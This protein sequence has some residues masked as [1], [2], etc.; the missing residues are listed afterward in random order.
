[1]SEHDLNNVYFLLGLGKKSLS[2]WYLQAS[3]D[4]I[5]YANEILAEYEM[6]FYNIESTTLQ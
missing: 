6:S 5:Q 4:D 1:M 2:K 3:D